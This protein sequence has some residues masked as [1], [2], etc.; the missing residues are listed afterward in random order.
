MNSNE[1]QKFRLNFCK[2]AAE[3][4]LKPSELLRYI[5]YSNT[6]NIKT[7]EK[8][9]TESLGKLLKDGSWVSLMAA[10]AGGASLGGLAAYGVHKGEGA[11]DPSGDMFGDEEDPIAE[12]KKLHLIAKYRNATNRLIDPSSSS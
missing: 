3:L 2:T 9:W 8:G 12:K 5:K 10:L 6:V 11:M 7:A 4:G 1:L